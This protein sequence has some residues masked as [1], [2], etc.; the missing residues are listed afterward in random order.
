MAPGPILDACNADD[1]A[2]SM[3]LTR[4]ARSKT[5]WMSWLIRK[6]SSALSCLINSPTW[7]VSWGPAP[8]VGFSKIKMPSRDASVKA[9]EAARSNLLAFLKTL[10]IAK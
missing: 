6:I 4:L 1:A 8:P 7:A 3:T 10:V 5:S 2:I 9:D